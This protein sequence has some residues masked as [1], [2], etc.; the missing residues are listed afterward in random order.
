MKMVTTLIGLSLVAFAAAAA[1]QSESPAPAAT[2]AAE[3]VAAKAPPP[4]D[5]RQRTSWSVFASQGFTAS[6]PAGATPA[7]ESPRVAVFFIHPTTFRGAAGVF[8]QDPAD[9]EAS[10]WTDASSIARQASAFTGCCSVYAPRYRAASSAGF[11]SAPPIREAAFALAYT[12]IERAFDAF[13]EQIGDRPFII[14]GHSQGAFHAATLLEKRIDGATL[15][16][17]LVAAYT[18]G[19]NLAEGEFGKRFTSV[20]PCTTPAATGCVVQWNSILDGVADPAK[21]ASVFQGPYV[22]KYGDDA[23]KLTLCIN[24]LTFDAANSE[25]SARLA[26]GAVPGAPGAGDLDPLKAEAVS[27]RCEQGLLL[28]KPDQALALEPLP[29]GGMH[30]HDMSLFWADIRAN[31]ALRAARFA[32]DQR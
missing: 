24:P 32:E 14:A 23:G 17:R 30:F 9:A 2:Y 19:I 3:D 5:Y 8:S 6:L 22:Q 11:A 7:A 13:L 26:K 21:L 28:V 29:N 31:A 27:A 16:Q 20:K 1:A 12:D 15:Q 25:G 18:I 10:K 4:L